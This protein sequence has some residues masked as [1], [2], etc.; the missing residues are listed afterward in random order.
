MRRLTSICPVAV[1]LMLGF[2]AQAAWGTV[3]YDLTG[4]W[5]PASVKGTTGSLKMTMGTNGTL[6]GEGELGAIPV[7]S[8]GGGETAA[9]N[10]V[11]TASESGGYEATAIG[12]IGDSGRCLSGIAFDTNY[13]AQKKVNWVVYVRSDYSASPGL[14]ATG[15]PAEPYV[16][17]GTPES[18]GHPPYSLSGN[19]VPASGAPEWKS[20]WTSDGLGD[21]IGIGTSGIEPIV[22][23]GHLGE[24]GRLTLI[25]G[26][27]N[28]PGFASFL[29]ATTGDDG[30]CVSATTNSQGPKETE[31]LALEPY[32]GK[33]G[34]LA[35]GTECAGSSRSTASHVSCSAFQPES[36]AEYFECTA[37]VADATGET[38]VRIPTGTVT[39]SAPAGSFPS[40]RSCTLAEDALAQQAYCSVRYVPYLAQ[41]PGS[42][43]QLTAAYGGDGYFNASSGE[44]RPAVAFGKT[45]GPEHEVSLVPPSEV[46]K[47]PIAIEPELFGETSALTSSLTAGGPPPK[48]AAAGRAKGRPKA[49]GRAVS[50]AAARTA[51]LRILRPGSRATPRGVIVY[52]LSHPLPAGSQLGVNGSTGPPRTSGGRPLAL[53]VRLLH[54]AYLFWADLSPG[55]R[56]GH[57]SILL[58]LEASNGHIAHQYELEG[59]PLLNR[60]PLVFLSAAG[61]G[62]RIYSRLVAVHLSRTQLKNVRSAFTFDAELLKKAKAKTKKRTRAKKG[63]PRAHKSDNAAH[64][65]FISLVWH[66]Q[67]QQSAFAKEGQLM[68]AVYSQNGVDTTQLGNS[69]E[70]DSAVSAAAAAGKT[71]VTI[72]I[73]GHGK[74]EWNPKERAWVN[75]TTGESVNTGIG[76]AAQQVATGPHG[77]GPEPGW[78]LVTSISPHGGLIAL[79]D[80]GHEKESTDNIT[81]DQLAQ[82]AEAHPGIKF[83]FVIVACASGSFIT[84][85]SV[86]PNVAS[87]ATSSAGNQTTAGNWLPAQIEYAPY[88]AAQTYALNLA[89]KK[90]GPNA[91]IDAVDRQ[92]LETAPSYDPAA[93]AKE[94]TP[95]TPWLRIYPTES[96]GIGV[97]KKEPQGI[98]DEPCTIPPEA[99]LD[100]SGQPWILVPPIPEEV[101]LPGG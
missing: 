44:T 62:D 47:R 83:N 7:T 59:E 95:S 27:P 74:I 24:T 77:K 29:S 99:Q 5:V 80:N 75:F 21:L 84:P 3:P 98:G 43:L 82:L 87:V 72:F 39:L 73:D 88:V 19:W 25:T 100:S 69:S 70:L 18:G 32:L 2:G 37:T 1:A 42:A 81:S 86:V 55:A 57:P 76:N 94:E 16:C 17:A 4:T 38:P 22:Q 92:A 58:V 64:S 35:G 68:Q 23:W 6:S 61:A 101:V 60:H 63:G 11:V 78:Q 56:Y 10:V 14:L 96:Y 93:L 34:L 20:T 26:T 54:P 15:N 31:V 28:S 65:Q 52:G 40:G 85:L 41:P 67:N 45:T 8:I 12:Q 50:Y 89:F 79:D 53:P 48:A 46:C 71:S 97:N 36:P 13:G 9:G 30:R 33:I 90:A 91:D 49:K 66:G 51:A